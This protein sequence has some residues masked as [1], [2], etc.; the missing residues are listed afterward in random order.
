MAERVT[1]TELDALI[2]LIRERLASGQSVC[3]SPRGISMR[4]MLRQGRDTVTLS[5]PPPRLKRYDLPL[6][7]RED[8]HYVLHRVIRVG[9]TYTCIGDNLFTREPG[10]SH[11]QVIAVVTAF[12][13][14]GKEH[15]VKELS[16]RLYC[17]LW[18]WI[19]PERYLWRKLK[20]LV[21]HMVKR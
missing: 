19:L 1:L 14:D 3:I 4:P 8:G 5:A 18:H 20:G 10:I 15:S 17:R 21:H 13:R 16:Y 6:Y 9:D 11:S 12:T 7:Q 2:P